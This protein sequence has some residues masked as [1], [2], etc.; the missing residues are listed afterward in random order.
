MKIIE[1]PEYLKQL[2]AVINTPD[3]KVI[4]G[5]RRSG[6]SILLNCFKKYL[7]KE[8]QNKANII[9]IDYNSAS[10]KSLLDSDSLYQYIE[11]Q[12]KNN[13]Q[14]FV[15]IDEV[16][17]CP[18]FE[19][20]IN[21]LHAQQKYQI[22]IT[23]SNAFLLSSDL[24][25]LFTGRTYEIEV[26]PFSFKEYLKYFQS[27]DLE[28]AFQ[29]YV[30]EGGMA[31][32]FVYDNLEEK[33]KYLR[34]VYDTLIVQDINNRHEIR[35]KALLAN[36]SDFLMDNISNQT[37]AR[38]IANATSAN[39]TENSDKTISNYIQYLIEAF[40]FYRVRRYDIRG[41]RY[42][43][44]QD[45]YYL[46]DHAFR[47]AKLGSRNMDYGRIYENI[48]AIE[49]MRRGYDIYIGTLYQK[50]IDFVATKR[51]EIIYIQ[52]ADDISHPD[53]LHREL[54]SLLSI[55]DAYP[56][57]IIANTRHDEYTKD[58]VQII[59]LAHWLAK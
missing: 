26:Y 11:S 25:T 40:A 19:K 6:K 7:I 15:L 1:R 50:E 9:H 56:K 12:Y 49:L 52:V 18:D 3:I 5:I 38:N 16:Q 37:S 20:T 14:N 41:K 23:G 53:T 48:V 45:K 59:D 30:L 24:A 39:N 44:S 34:G 21:Y 55:K 42:L 58:G 47:F 54:S 8:L 29:N 2:I 57:I 28:K 13:K 33:Y 4:T 43:A 27:N 46:A 35:N 17:M 10:S 31:G 51:N 36:V 32:N 22:Y